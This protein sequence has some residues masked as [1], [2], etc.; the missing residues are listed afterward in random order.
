MNKHIKAV[1]LL[2]AVCV[3]AMSAGTA[4]AQTGLEAYEGPG[5][6]VQ[7]QVQQGGEGDAGAPAAEGGAPVATSGGAE[8]G[9]A[10]P[11]T[12]LDAALILA[13]G[14][15]LLAVGLSTRRLTRHAD[16]G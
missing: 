16:A 1:M 6:D 7:G 14:G 9:G 2:A 3:L 4:F 8:G 5:E 11:F 10:L 13:V 12:G 15:V